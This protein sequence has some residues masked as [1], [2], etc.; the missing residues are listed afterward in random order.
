MYRYRLQLIKLLHLTTLPTLE[1]TRG[2]IIPEI[3]RLYC[4]TD[5]PNCQHHHS[6]GQYSLHGVILTPHRLHFGTSHDIIA[7]MIDFTPTIEQTNQTNGGQHGNLADN[8]HNPSL[9]FNEK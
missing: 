8:P 4:L 2:G 5:I 7:V 9:T 3:D 1:I 6:L